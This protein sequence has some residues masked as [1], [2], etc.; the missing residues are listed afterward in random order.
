LGDFGLR[1]EL[2]RGVR[3]FEKGIAHVTE[4]S[5]RSR[6]W[7]HGSLGGAPLMGVDGRFPGWE[8]GRAEP[9]AGEH[10]GP[11]GLELWFEIVPL[12]VG[13]VSCDGWWDV[14]P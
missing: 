6:P 12:S 9:P 7:R 13:E 1:Q 11:Q 8:A 14:V 10:C 4:T 3:R 5:T 2:D